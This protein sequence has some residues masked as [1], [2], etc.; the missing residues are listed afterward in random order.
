ME[1]DAEL[2]ELAVDR[3]GALEALAAE[4]HHRRE[5]Q[6]ALSVSKTTCHRIVRAFDEWDLVRRT[7][8]GYALSL[9]GR[10]V[11]DRVEAFADDVESATRM[12]SL[13]ELLES[14]DAPFDDRAFVDGV[15]DW[16][17]GHLE[18]FSIDEGLERVEDTELLRVLDWT[19]VPDLYHEKILRRLA[20]NEARVES[21]YPKAEIQDRLERFPDLH[22][23]LLEAGARPRYWVYEDVPPW[24]L[25]IYDDALAELRAYEPQSGAYLLEAT[26]D[27]PA[28]VE[29]ALD[30]F[31]EYRDRARALPDV[32]G[33]PD[34]G[35][36]TW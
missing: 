20:E 24:G 17:V 33:L 5:L 32:D 8:D 15:S 18:T 9:Y 27:A 30:V 7:D 29:W 36:Y 23:E 22:D 3:R 4:P 6:E 11:A 10:I 16:T 19:P 14:S 31:D 25:S 2:L 35:D 28:A 21:I 12:Q 34:W 1:F 13:L 26:S